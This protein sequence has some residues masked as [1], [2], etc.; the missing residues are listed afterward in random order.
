V[1]AFREDLPPHE[2]CRAWLE[3]SL[4]SDESLGLAE[5]V[6]AGTL[7]ILTH[8]Q[9]LDPPTPLADALAFVN[10]LRAQP[11]VVLVAPGPRH[12][13]IFEEL[14]RTTNARGNAI[15][16]AYLAALAIEVD[17]E[18]VTNDRGFA[19]FPGLRWRHPLAGR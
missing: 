10:E 8:P 2:T 3:R 14:C 16:D 19:R 9:I 4:E 13:S 6:L 11:N 5:S 7:R 17:G 1:Y 15:P 18:W 12:W